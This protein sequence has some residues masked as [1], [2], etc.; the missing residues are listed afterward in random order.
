MF[1]RYVV[2]NYFG[3]FL[4]E[5]ATRKTAKEYV[6]TDWVRDFVTTFKDAGFAVKPYKTSGKGTKLT[7][8]KKEAE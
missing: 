5:A 2:D 7:T 6:D 3:E 8:D 1:R 4:K